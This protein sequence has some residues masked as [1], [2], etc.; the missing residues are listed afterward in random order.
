MGGFSL[1]HRETRKR[2]GFS[3][4]PTLPLPLNGRIQL[5]ASWQVGSAPCRCQ[6]LGTSGKGGETDLRATWPRT[7]REI[8]CLDISSTLS[9]TVSLRENL[10]YQWQVCLGRYK[11][12][13]KECGCRA[14]SSPSA[15]L[16]LQF[17]LCHFLVVWH[18]TNEGISLCVDFSLYAVC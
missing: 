9:G 6:H 14:F 13:G 1:R 2:P 10:N 16:L 18:W 8:L 7:W 3:L 15:I 4:L 11:W 5:E 17:L 12:E